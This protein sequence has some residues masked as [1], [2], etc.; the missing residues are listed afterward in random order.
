MRLALAPRL[1]LLPA[2]AE[3]LRLT[4]ERFGPPVSDQ[5]TLLDESIA[6]RD[7]RLREAVEQA[8]AAAGPDAALRVVTVDPD[9]RVP[10]RRAMLA[11]YRPQDDPPA[12]S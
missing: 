8:H 1:A 4:V 6:A 7:A 12:R 11:P 2:P 9:S 5:R 10:E 3:V